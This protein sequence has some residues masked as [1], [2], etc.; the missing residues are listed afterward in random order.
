MKLEN[1]ISPRREYYKKYHDAR[2]HNPEFILKNKIT[3][4]K[5]YHE[6]K[7]DP[8]FREKMRTRVKLWKE[9]N[10]DL[11]KTKEYV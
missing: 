10:S 5:Y 1:H 8:G 3:Y 9:K 7:N 6:H 4:L 2:K 11:F